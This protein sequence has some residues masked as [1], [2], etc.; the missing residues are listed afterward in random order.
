MSCGRDPPAGKYRWPRRICTDCGRRLDCDGFVTEA[1]WQVQQNLHVPTCYP[2]IVA[3]PGEE[4]DPPQSKFSAVG[5]PHGAIRCLQ[6]EMPWKA[7]S[8]KKWVD[9]ERDDL[10]RFE[11]I[12]RHQRAMTLGGIGCSG[13]RP[14]VSANSNRNALKAAMIR[15]FRQLSDED[16][17]IRPWGAGPKPGIWQKAKEFIPTL[18]GELET[19]KMPLRSGWTACQPEERPPY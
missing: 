16:K 18:M 9:V 1:G 19:R 2:G 5:L 12:A 7:G 14:M 8:G 10:L 3:V 4:Y 11:R 6:G 17:A 13:A 15:L